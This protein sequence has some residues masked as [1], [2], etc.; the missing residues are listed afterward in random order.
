MELLWYPGICRLSCI[1][2]FYTQVLEVHPPVEGI[3]CVHSSPC[4]VSAPY[5]LV[6]NCVPS[7]SPEALA[8]FSVAGRVGSRALSCAS[9]TPLVNTSGSP[10]LCLPCCLLS[11]SLGS[12]IV[13]SVNQRGSRRLSEISTPKPVLS[14]CLP[15]RFFYLLIKQ[16][17]IFCLVAILPVSVWL[18]S[19]TENF[20]GKVLW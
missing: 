14:H 10:I 9:C 3:F 1:N 12:Q 5:R 7:P 4:A 17:S 15:G 13:F 2:V 20:R 11:I 19:M 6:S 8:Y 16:C 18:C